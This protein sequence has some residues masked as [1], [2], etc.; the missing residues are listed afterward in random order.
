MYD[1][2]RFKE[3]FYLQIKRAK[4]EI[5]ECRK[6]SF[7]IGPVKFNPDIHVF[8]VSRISVESNSVTADNQVTD[9]IIV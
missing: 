8:C 5:V 3:I 6:D 1:Y 9:L 4:A 7:C 2:V